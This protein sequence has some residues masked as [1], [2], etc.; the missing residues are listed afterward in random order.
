MSYCA[1]EDDAWLSARNWNH[2][3][4]TLRRYQP[5]G[6]AATA[7]ARAATAPQSFASG[8]VSPGGGRVLRVFAAQPGAAPPPSVP[9]S[10]L[11]LRALDRAGHVTQDVGVAVT[12]LTQHVDGASGGTFIAAVP[13][14]AAA[15]ELVRSGTVLDRLARSRPPHVRLLAPHHRMRI[16]TRG[17]LVVR[18]R[19]RDAD[20]D[21]RHGMPPQATVDF[22]P[23]NGRSWSGL[24]EGPDRG[25]ATIVGS[26]LQRSRHARIR[27]TVNDGFNEARRRSRAFR[28]DGTA[29]AARIV[30]PQRAAQLHPGAR[31]L[32]LGSAFDDHARRLRGRALTWFAGHKRLGSGEQLAVRLPAGRYR[33][34]LVARDR[35]GRAGVAALK[36]RVR[37]DPLRITRIGYKARVS[38]R[39]Q[40]LAVT[41]RTSAPATLR[42][43]G[44]RFRLGAGARRVVLR[45]PRRPAAGVLRIPVT[46]AASGG[47]RLTGTLRLRRG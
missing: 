36:V 9:S 7:T 10:P 3:M 42:A 27:V 47:R 13:P 1:H 30:A 40:K 33:L 20:G 18:W 45:L 43:R 31:S 19:T 29:P 8:V 26:R 14:S 11:R 12:P 16:R 25:K 35:D 17:R 4:D 41:I 37:R 28:A 24:Y 39:T 2:T 21:P 22:S 15:V 46:L 44:R 32:L 38:R 6:R 5:I 23:D 34:Y